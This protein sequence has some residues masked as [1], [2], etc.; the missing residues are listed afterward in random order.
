VHVEVGGALEQDGAGGRPLLGGR[1]D[2]LAEPVARGRADSDHQ[3]DVAVGDKALAVKR[4]VTA[5]K[6]GVVADLNDPHGGGLIAVVGEQI[7]GRV[8]ECTRA[9]S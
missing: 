7:S 3:Q 6:T 4:P 2:V 1:R 8:A 9:K 5:L